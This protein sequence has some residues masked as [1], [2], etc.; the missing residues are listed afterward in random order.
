M[1]INVIPYDRVRCYLD[2]SLKKHQQNWLTLLDTELA[3]LANPSCFP[4]A[5]VQ[6]LMLKKALYDGLNAGTSVIPITFDSPLLYEVKE[7]WSNLH[8]AFLSAEKVGEPPDEYLVD[9]RP[10]SEVNFKLL[11]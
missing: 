10:D 5:L 9:P 8:G 4:L 11:A 2:M 6:K 3:V 1:N 7:W